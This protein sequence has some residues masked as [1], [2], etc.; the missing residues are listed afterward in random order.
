MKDNKTN[1]DSKTKK[2]IIDT[3]ETI[4]YTDIVVANKYTTLEELKELFVYSDGVEL[5]TCITDGSCTTSTVKR[6]SDNKFCILIKYNHE[7]RIKGIN[8]TLDLINTVSHE[9]GHAVL[10]IYESISQ[11]V[12]NCSPEPFCYLLGYIA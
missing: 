10:D 4:Y 7:S 5:D 11:N 2:S 1:R 3:Y 12:C 9:A 6:K 8:K